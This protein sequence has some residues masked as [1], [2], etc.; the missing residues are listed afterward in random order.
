M[1]RRKLGLRGDR[2]LHGPL[3][4]QGRGP[5][6][7]GQWAHRRAGP[8]LWLQRSAPGRR[9]HRNGA[10]GRPAGTGGGPPDGGQRARPAASLA[11]TLR[12][13]AHP[14]AADGGAARPRR[15]RLG[16]GANG[17]PADVLGRGG[18]ALRGVGRRTAAVRVLRHARGHRAPLRYDP[19]GIDTPGRPRSRTDPRPSAGSLLL[20]G[21]YPGG[22]PVSRRRRRAPRD[23]GLPR[24]WLQR[25][26]TRR[27]GS[28]ALRAGGLPRPS[29]D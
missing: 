5:R 22:G 13:A 1:G 14:A 11:G 20:L 19:G 18:R 4:D 21:T 16:S 29:H 12:A 26:G 27:R 17:V 2:T 10:E 6:S 24:W 25:R 23:P 28:R 9:A 15:R 3:R 7:G 8:L